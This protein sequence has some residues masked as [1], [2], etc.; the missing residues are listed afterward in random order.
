MRKMTHLVVVLSLC[1]IATL[2]YGECAE[3][4]VGSKG[5]YT[6]LLTGKKPFTK[7]TLACSRTLYDNGVYTATCP[8]DV[9]VA[10]TVANIAE[11]SCKDPCND[12]T[13][14]ACGSQDAGDGSYRAAC[15]VQNSE[16]TNDNH[17]KFCAST[18][19]LT[20]VGSTRSLK[21]RFRLLAA[22][23]P[24]KVRRDTRPQSTTS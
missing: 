8:T 16:G 13:V 4:T 21:I 6:F 7:L 20:Y 5:S 24:Q 17:L 3:Q 18:D 9:T 2:S 10:P 22:S 11:R 1:I 19:E 14:E 15:K 23:F 12:M